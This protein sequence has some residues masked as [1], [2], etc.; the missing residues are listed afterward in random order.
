MQTLSVLILF[1]QKYNKI[2][3]SKEQNT[4]EINAKAN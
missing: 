2:Q 3:Y 1:M 4:K